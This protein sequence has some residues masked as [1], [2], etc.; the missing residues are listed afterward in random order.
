MPAFR[1]I[2]DIGQPPQAPTIWRLTV[3][4]VDAEQHQVAAVHLDGGANVFEGFL[5][6]RQIDFGSRLVGNRGS[7]TRGSGPAH[8]RLARQKL[9]CR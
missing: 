5:E 1:V 2:I 8:R 4:F 9:A 3:P 7:A 6:D